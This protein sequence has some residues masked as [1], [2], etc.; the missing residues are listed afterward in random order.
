MAIIRK[1][2]PNQYRRTNAPPLVERKLNGR[3]IVRYTPKIT[4]ITRKLYAVFSKGAYK[5]LYSERQ[6]VL[7][8]SNIEGWR[9]IPQFSNNEMATY[10]SRSK[11]MFVLAFRGTEVTNF[12]DLLNDVAIVF[13]KSKYLPRVREGIHMARLILRYI[14]T[15]YKDHTLEITGHSL[16]G[17]IGL[18]VATALELTAYLYNIGSSP[19]DKAMDIILKAVCAVSKLGDCPA[20]KNIVH[21]HV[22]GDPISTSAS[23]AVPWKVER[24]SPTQ[25]LNPH[26]ID[27]FI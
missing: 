10:Y 25:S 18:N 5:K 9:F 13:G 3:D 4:P 12:K 23:I 15:R 1:R 27:N 8:D 21:F 24:Q 17:K 20:L 22:V 11:K 16:G 6:Q 26:T 14:R 7:A 2:R 19:A